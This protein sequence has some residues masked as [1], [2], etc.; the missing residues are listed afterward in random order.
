AALG[1]A[2]RVIAIESDPDNLHFLRRSLTQQ[3]IVGLEV[4]EADA[5]QYRGPA[6][7][8]LVIIELID[9]WLL[10]EDYARVISA[11]WQNGIVDRNTV[12]V[13]SRYD[14]HLDFGICDWKG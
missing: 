12:F 6:R 8:D 5:A 3:K 2:E 13:P 10:A 1:V 14:F 7:A 11:L 4:I 9:T